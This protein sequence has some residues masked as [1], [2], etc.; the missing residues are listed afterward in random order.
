MK[1]HYLSILAAVL[2]SVPCLAVAASD[3]HRFDD[4]HILPVL[5]HVNKAGTVTLID[6]AYNLRPNV[7]RA[8][9]QT[10]TGM[11]S[12]AATKNGKA[13]NSQFVLML[14]LKPVKGSTNQYKFAYFSMKPVPTGNW[15]WVHS[16]SG[17]DKSLQLVGGS[18][19]LDFAADV[20]MTCGND[21][22][23]KYCVDPSDEPRSSGGAIF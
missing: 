1:K 3:A 11:I 18:D 6:P 16:V 21:H 9:E 7:K 17:G 13:I 15:H 5:V 22:E 12:K 4:S 19:S 2:L 20:M 14:A 8:V 10:V 23:S